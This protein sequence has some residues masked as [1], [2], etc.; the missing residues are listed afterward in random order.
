[1][2]G[3]REPILSESPWRREASAR[4]INVPLSF[5][6]PAMDRLLSSYP[7][8]IVRIACDLC[9]RAGQHRLARLA[10]KFGAECPLDEVLARLAGDCRARQDRRDIPKRQWRE[11]CWARLPDLDGAPM[12]PDVPPELK[13]PRLVASR[14]ERPLGYVPRHRRNP[15]RAYDQDGREIEPVRI[16]SM[17]ESGLTTVTA[18]C[19][20]IGCG[21]AARVDVATWRGD[22]YVPDIGLHLRC[23]GCG[24]RSTARI[25]PD[26]VKWKPPLSG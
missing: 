9:G 1:M 10:A 6:F 11:G 3:H 13:R 24:K 18:I 22:I 19:N 2:P 8:V 5:L 14:P 12:P 7:F 21:H 20:E 16:A 26:H 23:L 15:R 4:L 17:I 25:H